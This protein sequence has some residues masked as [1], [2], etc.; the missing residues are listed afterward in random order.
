MLLYL[1]PTMPRLMVG[2]PCSW[3]V[4]RRV[5]RFES[6]IFPGWR[7]SSGFSS[8][9]HAHKHTD[10]I[11]FTWHFDSVANQ[12]SQEHISKEQ[13]EHI[14]C[15]VC[16][17]TSFPVDM[18]ATTGNLCTLTSV[19]PT[20]ASRPISDGPICVPLANTHSPRRMSW[21]IGLSRHV[22]LF[23]NRSV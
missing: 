6:R 16:V 12:N 8:Y 17:C 2:Y 4:A 11:I 10:Q 1:S 3:M 23:I 19:T 18:T 15:T 5:E 20:V 14:V 21:P 9:T 22:T 7:S 13:S